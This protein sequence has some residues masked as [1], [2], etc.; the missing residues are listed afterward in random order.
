MD[1]KG[2]ERLR[3]SSSSHHTEEMMDQPVEALLKYI[4]S[5][6]QKKVA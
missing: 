1:Q 6:L 2:A 5:S 4:P 3:F